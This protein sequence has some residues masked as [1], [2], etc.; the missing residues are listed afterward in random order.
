MKLER[1]QS[2]EWLAC[3]GGALLLVA[4]FL[5]W[6]GDA[7]AWQAFDVVDVIL[8]IAALAGIGVAGFAAANAKTDAPISSAALTVPI[9]AVATLLVLYRL[10]DPVAGLAREVGLYLGLLAAAGITYGSWRS[11]RDERA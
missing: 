10:I 11:I 3:A 5:P 7:D 1:L 8:L 6:F 9:G 2:G 4:L